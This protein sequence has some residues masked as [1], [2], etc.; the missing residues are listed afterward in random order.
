MSDLH[1]DAIKNPSHYHILDGVES[2]TVIASAMTVE[3]WRG[4]CLG[5][6]L[7]YRIRAGKKD[8]LE[9]DIGKADFY[10]ELFVQHK[11]LCRTSVK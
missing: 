1:L 5:N 9:Q 8:K 11:H 2:I 3:E 10:N 4:F 7:K 6:I